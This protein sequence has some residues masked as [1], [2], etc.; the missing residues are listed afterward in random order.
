MIRFLKGLR[1]LL[2]FA[3]SLLDWGKACD[4]DIAVQKYE[5]PFYKEIKT[6]MK[7]ITTIQ[8]FELSVQNVRNALGRPAKLKSI[9]VW[10]SSDPAVA[11]VAVHEDGLLCDVLPVAAGTSDITVTADGIT[12]TFQVAVDDS[13][14]TD[15]DLVASESSLIQL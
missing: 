2:T 11:T 13:P 1:A 12:K 8:T 9:P 5:L 3:S 7:T 10:A 14:A 4:F 6:F 15:F